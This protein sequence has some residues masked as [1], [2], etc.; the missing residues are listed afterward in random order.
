MTTGELQDA[1]L[2]YYLNQGSPVVVQDRA[3]RQK[4]WFWLTKTAKRVWNS[5]PYFFRKADGVVALTSGVGT[6]PSDFSG[7]GTQEQIYIQGQ[8]YRPLAYKAPD[9]IK[10]QIQN[11]PQS[12]SPWAY[13]LYGLSTLG[14]PKILCWPT[15]NSI[16][17]VRAYDRLMPE[18]VDKPLAPN[19]TLNGVGVLTGA[20]SY[21]ITNVTA[22]GE[23]EG[24]FVS[25]TL[26]ATA[27]QVLVSDIPTWWGRTVTSRRLY[28]T[29]AG[30]NQYKLVSTGATLNDNLTTTFSDN[31][32]DGTLGANVPTEVNAVSGLE[33]FPN[34][35]HEAALYDGL[36]FQLARGQG[37]NRDTRFSAEWDR[38]VQ[39]MWE[40]IQQGQN[41]IHAFP[42][43]P[44][45]SSGHPVWSRWVPPA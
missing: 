27:N 35:F 43:F 4:S 21:L 7:A 15:D 9:W 39:R 42:A 18:L 23:T 13:T 24:G 38:S 30:G 8:K 16:L 31:T 44:G 6:M 14:V 17:D 37:D 32:A 45:G 28:R 22:V 26:T 1:G 5:A 33:Q 12:G 3:Q 25:E 10:F 40:E 19:V 36:V 11:S 34:G 29:A 2:G 41:E 20:Y